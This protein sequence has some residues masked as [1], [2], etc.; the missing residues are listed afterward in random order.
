MPES[1]AV[2]GSGYVGTVVAA[3]LAHV[4]HEV[5]GL[6]IDEAKCA[7]L[8]LGRAPF[9][10]PG[11]DPLIA[12]GLE[13]GNL[14]FT[15]DVGDAIGAADIVFL[16][17]GTPAGDDGRSDVQFLR[18]AVES[19]AEAMDGPKTLVTKST[20]PIGSGQWLQTTLEDAMAGRS[21]PRIPFSVVSNPEFLR[22]GSAVDDF[23]HPERV[24]LGSDESAALELLTE[25]YG[26]ILDQAFEGGARR[27]LPNL[28]RTGLTT[29]ETVKYAANAFLAMKISFANEIAN[30]CELVGADVTEVADAIGL[31][32]RIGRPFLDAG[33][34]WGGSCFGKDVAEL[35]AAAG[36]H[37]YDARLLRA[38]IEVNRW[39]R[40]LVVRKL[41]RRLHGLRGRRIGL[42]G[43]A[44]KPDTDDLRDA[45]ALDIARWLIEGG[46]SVVA[47]DP[48]VKSL[49]QVPEVLLVG[50][51]YE[52]AERADAVVLVTDWPQYRALE[53][54]V[55]LDRMRGRLFVDGRGVFDPEKIVAA[56][57]V[58]E[59]I[60]RTT[61]SLVR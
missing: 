2:V 32:G 50:D 46:A 5:V 38:T 36:D 49:P 61:N 22:Q 8:R 44:F 57:L 26:P 10:E 21:Q 47:H 45:P 17:V 28:V 59:G 33:I 25:V 54:D 15:S 43:L 6:E 9:F 18:H 24:V 34:G 55:L 20:V 35:V 51:A 4:G 48:V 39:Q 37:G 56:G 31:D 30:V 27:K 40:G 58:F 42:L 19:I 14:R 7:R 13:R 41:R 29:A 60:G 11:L 3:C 1:I 52:A 12:M 16:C 53:F 23:L